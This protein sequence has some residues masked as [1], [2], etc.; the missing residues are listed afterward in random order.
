[1]NFISFI[2]FVYIKINSMLY[3]LIKYISYKFPQYNIFIPEYDK[4]QILDTDRIKAF[5]YEILKYIPNKLLYTL[6]YTENV[7]TDLIFLLRLYKTIVTIPE[8]IALGR[9]KIV[10]ICTYGDE[11]FTLAT[12]L[13]IKRTTTPQEFIMHFF[14]AFMKLSLKGYS[15]DSFDVLLVKSITGDKHETNPIKQGISFMNQARAYSTSSRTPPIQAS[16]TGIDIRDILLEDGPKM[17]DPRRFIL[18][19]QAKEKRMSKLAAFDIET[20]VYEGKLYPYAIG[21]QYIKYNKVHKIIFY[22]ENKYNSIEKNSAAILEDMI[23]YITENCKHYT[24]FAHNLGKFDGILMMSSIFNVLGP[25]S[26][27]I[28]KDNSIITMSFKGIKLLDSLRIFP[29]SLKQLAIQFDVQTKKGEFDHKKVT[30]DNVTSDEIKTEV[31]Q[32]LEGDISSLHECMIKASNDIFNKYNFNISDVYSTSSL[33]MK[34]FRTNYLDG[35]GIPLVPRHMTDVIS[36]AYYGGISQVYKTHGYNLKYYDINSLYPWA[37]T[38][39]M[40]YEYIGINKNLKLKDCFGFVYASIYIPKDLNYK[41]LPMRMD[42]SLATPSG[43]IIGVYFSEELK[44][45]ESL[46]CQITVHKAYQY[47]RKVI[48]KQYVED[49]Y[50]QKAVAVGADRVFIKLLL[51]GLYGFFARTDEKYIAVFLPLDDALREAQIYPAYNIILMDNDESA[52]LIREVQP[53]KELCESTGHKYSDY[54]DINNRSRSKSN[55]AIAA[56]ITGYSRIKIHQFK[57]ICGDVYYSDTDSIV[58]GNSLDDKYVNNELGMMKDEFKGQNILE[59]IF[60]SPKL[61]GL[62]LDTGEEIIKARGVP[63]EVGLKFDDLISINNGETIDFVKS[64]QLFKSLNAFSI[65]SKDVKGSITRNTPNGKIPIYNEENTHIIGYDDIHRGLITAVR[66][67]PIG[68]KLTGRIARLI[69]MY[70]QKL[71]QS[72]IDE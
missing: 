56:A 17:R 72:H 30:I 37:M 4:E 66:D 36:E 52:L 3:R 38:Q 50:A 48:F 33:A 5:R 69:K 70:R 1:M 9:V 27:I 43:N 26:I 35:E 11:M 61:Y 15:V 18:P 41:P 42:D 7:K 39:D 63:K 25:H 58:T 55:R 19:L 65:T 21:L 28:G 2:Y 49:I 12:S 51:N 71:S 68:Y 20:F 44:Y 47:T 46:G 59:G 29:M 60:V 40:P 10:I 6:V 57:D 34:H 53:S 13:P 32:Y 14:K 64:D 31:M 62:R 22:Y 24:I 23:N 16:T 54:F 45:A 67:N 8:F